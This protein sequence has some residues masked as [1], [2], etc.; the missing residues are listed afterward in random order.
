MGATELEID[1]LPAVEGVRLGVM[2]V[3]EDPIGVTDSVADND[4]DSVGEGGGDAG[5]ADDVGLLELVGLRDPAGLFDAVR[6]GLGG[7]AEGLGVV[8]GGTYSEIVVMAYEYSEPANPKGMTAATKDT[9]PNP[10]GGATHRN[11]VLVIAFL[12]VCV[13]PHLQL[14]DDIFSCFVE[15]VT[16][17]LLVAGIV[18]PVVQLVGKVVFVP[19]KGLIIHPSKVVVVP[20]WNSW[21]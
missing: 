6:E 14:P 4:G 18:F 7:A 8:L 2:E 5:P 1:G 21:T 12:P 9:L 20:V 11:R 10:L 3:L 16:V 15:S 19:E 17:K 13:T